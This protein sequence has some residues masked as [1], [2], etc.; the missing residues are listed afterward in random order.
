MGAAAQQFSPRI[1]A[2]SVLLQPQLV[3]L[4]SRLQG[5]CRASRHNVQVP[6]RKKREGLMKSFPGSA[7]C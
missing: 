6:G 1:Q 2:P 5:G 3:A 7:T 4:S